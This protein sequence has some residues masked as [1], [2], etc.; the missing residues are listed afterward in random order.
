MPETIFD[1][2]I[3]TR[4]FFK[5]RREILTPDYLPEKLPHRE[6]EI[7]E[8]ASILLPSIKGAKPSNIFIFGKSGT[9][10]TAVSKYIGKEIEEG[11]YQNVHYK[12]INCEFVDTQ[13]GILTQIGNSFIKNDSEKIPHTGWSIE[14][15]LTSLKNAIENVGGIAIIVL[16]EIDKLVTRSGDDILYDITRLNEE[17]KNS[18]LSFIGL[19]N[20]TKFT[21]LLD[22][23]VKSSLGAEELVFPP[24][25]AE[26][27][28]DI[29][30]QRAELAFEK[31]VLDPGV[32]P[33]CAAIAAKEHGDAR[34]A[35]NLLRVS[36]E[37][38]ERSNAPMIKEEHVYKAKNR[39]ELDVQTSVISTLPLHSKLILLGMILKY[40]EGDEL[41][42]TGELYE[43]YKELSRKSGLRKEIVT[44]RRI[45]DLIAELDML[46]IIN[47]R[48]KSFGRGGRTK[49]IRLAV[50]PT[51]TKKILLEDEILRNAADQRTKQLRLI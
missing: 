25:N 33:L 18:K 6:K 17:L 24:Y 28:Q 5:G 22:T 43:I 4:S 29:L 35:L 45:A 41:M 16:D 38:A 31:D 34:K 44:Q 50:S 27:L 15:V 13:Y 30:K 32:I 46:G 36:A 37:I 20:D 12:Y 39:V 11:K 21:D 47:A 7:D 51:E 9:G 23:R 42:T 48:I 2:L 40:E 19:T 26:Q 3:P 14:K 8:I 10:K 1:K 49:E